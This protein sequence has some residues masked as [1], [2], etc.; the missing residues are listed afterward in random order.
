LEAIDAVRVLVE[1]VMGELILDA[2]QYEQTT[3]HLHRQ[4]EHIEQGVR[5]AV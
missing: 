5:R 1:V 3:G 2:E 4:A